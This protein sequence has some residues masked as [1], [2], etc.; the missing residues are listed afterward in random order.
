M[1]Y[2]LCHWDY[3][4]FEFISRLIKRVPINVIWSGLLLA[5]A[6]ISF[7]NVGGQ[8]FKHNGIYS[9]STA[10]TTKKC[11]EKVAQIA[12][13][14]YEYATMWSYSPEETITF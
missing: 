7:F 9:Y 3:Y 5:L 10:T 4:V 8:V 1:I 2:G 6:L 12:G 11:N 13:N 14:S